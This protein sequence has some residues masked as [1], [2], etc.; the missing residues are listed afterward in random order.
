MKSMIKSNVSNTWNEIS[1]M[2]YARK[3]FS[4]RVETKT[5]HCGEIINGYGKINGYQCIQES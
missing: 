5:G 4:L 3:T 1:A 2:L